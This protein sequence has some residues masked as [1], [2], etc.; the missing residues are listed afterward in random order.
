PARS[1]RPCCPSPAATPDRRLL[2]SIRTASAP[3][4]LHLIMTLL[5][6]HCTTLRFLDHSPLNRARR[7]TSRQIAVASGEPI[8]TAVVRKPT[9]PQ[10]IADSNQNQSSGPRPRAGS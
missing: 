5:P 4:L 8:R 1:R 7:A 2:G 6:H 9:A 3:T 10:P